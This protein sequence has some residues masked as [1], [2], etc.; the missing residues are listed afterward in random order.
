MGGIAFWNIFWS[1]P[2]TPI[3]HILCRLMLSCRSLCCLLWD[4]VSSFFSLWGSIYIVSIA[5]FKI[6]IL[7]SLIYNILLS[8]SSEFFTLDIMFFSFRE[9]ICSTFSYLLLLILIFCSKSFQGSLY[10]FV[11]CVGESGYFS[12]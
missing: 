12:H 1:R 3:T 7:F 5:V 8:L 6:I 9:S 2:M 4:F 11:C 10:L